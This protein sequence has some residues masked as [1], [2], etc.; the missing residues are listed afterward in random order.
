[1]KLKWIHNVLIFSA[2]IHS[3]V[4]VTAR[5][6]VFD[7]LYYV[8][9]AQK[10][11]QGIPYN[12]EHPPLAKAFIALSIA[13]FGNNFIAWRIPSVIFALTATYLTY[14]IAKKY[15]S[16]KMATYS[17][18]LLTCSTIFLI[19]GS[20][21]TLDMPMLA[22][23]LLGIYAYLNKK[24]VQTGVWLGLAVL[25]KETAILIAAALWIYTWIKRDSKKRIL[26]LTTIF[27]IVSFAGLSIYDLAYHQT[28]TIY[29]DKG[30]A[31]SPTIT[32]NNPFS[33]IEAVWYYQR[34][35]VTERTPNSTQNYPP[36]GWVTPFDHN[37]FNPLSWYWAANYIGNTTTLGKKIVN[38]SEQPNPFIEYTT[39]PLLLTLP[40]IAWKKHKEEL[41]LLW[42]WIAFTYLP[43]LIIGC[44]GKIEASFYI[45]SATPALTIGT[46]YYLSLIQNRKT[47]WIIATLYL[48][49]AITFFLY[50]FPINFV[51]R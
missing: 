21:G 48:A 39:F 31:T 13:A 47:K 43:W 5:I 25:A 6:K 23:S 49:G 44:F 30:Q 4:I 16:E 26:I 29:N 46:A 35:L 3:I 32:I 24:T 7:E 33:H 37:S 1:M 12:F 36:I 50:Y 42:L 51:G 40:F 27:L 20:C 11:L 18:A 15:M 8:L 2:V 19:V 45:V 28:V 10:M 22:L 38:W 34:T 9:A 14:L 41:S 17:A